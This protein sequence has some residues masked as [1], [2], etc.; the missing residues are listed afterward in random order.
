M[1]RLG[2][3]C[4]SLA[5]SIPAMGLSLTI[6]PPVA[7]GPG[8]QAVV[9]KTAALFAV[10][11]EDCPVPNAGS[12]SA[13]GQ[14][15]VNGEP[16]AVAVQAIPAG[17]G[18]FLVSESQP[19]ASAGPLIVS[20]SASCAEARAGAIVPVLNQRFEREFLKFFPSA[21]SASEI[22][23]ALSDAEKRAIVKP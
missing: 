3:I 5:A 15:S 20:I 10:R 18:V 13:A 1:V 12:I 8:G 11:L 23:R 7:A 2:V 19:S 22:N 21:P 17:P 14:R 9:K 4:V 6:G 16:T